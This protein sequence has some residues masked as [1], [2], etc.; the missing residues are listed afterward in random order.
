[1]FNEELYINKVLELFANNQYPNIIQIC[2]ADGGSTDR[3]R[4]IVLE[5]S[6]RDE[7]II[8][9]ENPEK[10]QSHG[11]NKILELAKGELFLRADGHSIYSPDYVTESVNAIKKSG[12]ANVGGTQRYVA[13][14]RV[15]AGI[16]LAAK[17]FF[18]NGG[19]KYM[20]ENFEGYS[21]TVFLG[22][23][24]TNVLKAL[25]GFSIINRTNEDSEINLR[26]REEAKETIY[27]SP[28]I[29][30]WYYPRSNFL[31][32]IKQYIRYGRGRLITNNIHKGNIPYRSKAPFFFISFMI[33]YGIIDTIIAEGKI[34]FFYV[35]TALL[36]LIFFESL[37][38]CYEKKE[39]FKK[40]IWNGEP[41]KSPGLISNFLFC[42]VSLLI[43]NISHFIGYG[44]QLVKMKLLKVKNW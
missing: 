30:C 5:Y 43:M 10:F 24:K 35:S 27:V 2:V 42:F 33:L 11:L 8:L 23:F 7:R 28:Y 19:A 36:L 15:Q 18:G 9:I 32:L 16:A 34:G 22:C 31:S 41:S 6:E 40:E 14:N 38:F 39:Y 12:A 25:G 44:F 37:R 20:D 17:N 3:T 1:M 29:K 13:K 4:D 21:D 26:I